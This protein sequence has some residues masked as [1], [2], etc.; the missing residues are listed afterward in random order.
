MRILAVVATTQERDALLREVGAEPVRVGPYR[1]VTTGT[2]T[3]VVG[4]V[5]PAAAAAA[6]ATALALSP[7]DVVLSL[8]IC[9]GF[10]G[11]ADLGDVVVATDLVA[12]DLGADSPS[13]FLGLDELGWAEESHQVDPELVKTAATRLGEVVTGP[14]LTVSTVTGTDARAGM[15]AER[16]GAVAEAMEGW[17]VLEAA[18]PH[19]LP[20]LEVRTVSNRVGRRDTATW[21]FPRAFASLAHVGS[22]LLEARWL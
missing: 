17:G 18:R 9:G 16:H 12:A 14:V 4:G 7:Y 21:D 5:G 13:G 11:A 15:L 10:A 8:G 3:L 1:A 22:A 19:G 6:T 2:G 20:V